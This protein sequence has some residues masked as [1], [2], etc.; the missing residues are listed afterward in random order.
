MDS[1]QQISRKSKKANKKGIKKGSGTKNNK[2]LNTPHMN[3]NNNKKSSTPPM[4][5][6][7]DNSDND[8]N[9]KK[10]STPPMS[11]NS[12]N[13][14]ND[15]KKSSTP[16]MS[17]NSD[18]SD[19]DNKKSSTPPMSDNSDN[20]KKSSTPPMSNNSDN[21]NVSD[22]S[23]DHDSGSDTESK[24]PM[25]VISKKVKAK[26][27][28]KADAKAEA[29]SIKSEQINTAL[30]HLENLGNQIDI[31]SPPDKKKT[32][33][34]KSICT[35][36]NKLKTLLLIEQTKSESKRS[37]G[38]GGKGTGFD[39]PVIMNNALIDVLNVNGDNNGTIY[40]ISDE[41]SQNTIK[42]K[43]W[44]INK[45]LK[46]RNNEYMELYSEDTDEYRTSDS[47]RNKFLEL[48]RNSN[49][50]ELAIGDDKSI[51][52]NDIDNE[53]TN[54]IINN[55]PNTCYD[56]EDDYEFPDGY[57]QAYKLIKYNC[58]KV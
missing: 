33:S 17:D 34:I 42:S 24:L 11:D 44:A 7:S 28:A 29:K 51:S 3:D 37:N 46:I 18:N 50:I 19:N 9:N 47:V 58:K 22:N 35:N 39:A 31:I 40:N 48:Y 49:R 13:S 1:P 27:P 23:S 43:L 2:Q 8:N 52:I 4:S 20:N 41:M 45:Q 54:D 21:D 25:P 32:R 30:I 36:I 12:D 53:V 5:D 14:D 26:K 16:P 10:S 57:P 56:I 38:S 55:N 15:N 6:N